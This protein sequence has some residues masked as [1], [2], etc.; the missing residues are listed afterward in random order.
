MKKKLITCGCSI[1]YGTE[2]KD[3]GEGMVKP[4]EFAWPA[5]LAKKM[6]VELENL[7]YPG[8]GNDYI[9][10]K[11]IENVNIENADRVIVGIMW[12]QPDRFE[13]YDGNTWKSYGPWLVDKDLYKNISPFSD[14]VPYK[15][16]VDHYYIEGQNIF[17]SGYKMLTNILLLQAYLTK[18]N[19]NYFMQFSHSKKL[20]T[21][22]GEFIFNMKGMEHF[23]D[24]INWDSF[25][26][27]DDDEMT[28]FYEI[29]DGYLYGTNGHYLEEAHRDY[30][31]DYLYPW[32][33]ERYNNLVGI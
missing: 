26:F 10:R 2:L 29:V 23:R 28:S 25:F 27:Y 32:I 21:P 22:N 7:A 3:I 1:T 13:H 5:L 14:F 30:V 6:G 8:V 18:L 20:K 19:I 9:V 17:N 11:I 16:W 24:Y 4:S 15:S 31:N 33:Y 12:S